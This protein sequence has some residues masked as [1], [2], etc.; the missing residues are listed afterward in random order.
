MPKRG[1]TTTVANDLAAVK[2]QLLGKCVRIV[3]ADTRMFLKPLRV[4]SV[5]EATEELLRGMF[6]LRLEGEN[7]IFHVGPGDPIDVYED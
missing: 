6:A 2:E 4:L 3:Y 7:S 1:H 5:S